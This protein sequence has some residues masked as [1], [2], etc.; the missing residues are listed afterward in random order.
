LKRRAV[1][2]VWDKTGII[3]LARVLDGAG[4]EILST[5]KTAQ[6]LRDAGIPV[7][8]ISAYT[9]SPEILGGRVKTLHPKIAGGILTT[10]KDD[11]VPPID[12][13]VC[14]LYP[15]ADGLARGASR[16][17]LVELIDIGGITLLRAAAKNHAFVAIV[18]GPEYYAEVEAE[19]RRDGEVGPA[20]RQKLATAAF[21]ITSRYD[22]AIAV[23]LDTI[24]DK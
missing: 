11:T 6:A 20:L 9:G 3:D 13:V 2:S 8:E 10:R 1:I 14:N 4:Y 24:S 5:S 7:V 21:H 22:T 18:P 16:A 23:W 19:L 15:F 12:V 17:E